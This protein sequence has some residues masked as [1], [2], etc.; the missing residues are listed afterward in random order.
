MNFLVDYLDSDGVERHTSFQADAE[1]HQR[2]MAAVQICRS[3]K[4]QGYT[5]QHLTCFPG[6]YSLAELEL[7]CKNG[8]PRCLMPLHITCGVVNF[9]RTRCS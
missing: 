6:D 3:L 2:H 9:S 8:L 7:M 5:P 4:A 1:L